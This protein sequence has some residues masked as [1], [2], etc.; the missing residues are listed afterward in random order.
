[1]DILQ[2]EEILKCNGYKITSQ[3]RAIIEVL[4]ENIGK[5]LSAEEILNLSKE[6]C[7]QTNFSTVYR[8]LEV[9]EELELVHKTNI[10]SSNTFY[11]EIIDLDEHHHHIICTKCGK[12]QPIE[13]CPIEMFKEKIKGTDFE[14]LD[15][16][17][18]IYGLCKDCKNK[19]KK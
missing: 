3:R 2:L 6:K 7:A 1:M 14:V 12:T 13:F 5:F 4:C 8:N 19:P 18:E 17:L 15:H 11:Y 10:D 9:L 16:K